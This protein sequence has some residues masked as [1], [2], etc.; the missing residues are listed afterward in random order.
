MSKAK[1]VGQ[2]KP[3]PK[4]SKLEQKRMK[5]FHKKG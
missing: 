3:A 1:M 5:N 2:F 4:Q